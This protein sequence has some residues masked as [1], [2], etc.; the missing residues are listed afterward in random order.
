MLAA[1]GATACL[2]LAL[3]LGARALAWC[4]ASRSHLLGRSVGV[5]GRSLSLCGVLRPGVP[6][7]SDAG[8]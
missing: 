5:G 3:L 2:F 7:L 4:G 8:P 1:L 6:E